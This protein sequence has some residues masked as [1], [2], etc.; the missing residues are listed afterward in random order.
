MA[1]TPGAH[2]CIQL[3]V[4]DT[5]CHHW[6]RI[7][8]PAS[9][10]NSVSVFSFVFVFSS[11]LLSKFKYFMRKIDC[12]T[13]ALIKTNCP[14]RK[15]NV[16]SISTKMLKS[17]LI[18]A[19]VLKNKNST[20]TH[21]YERGCLN[22]T[23][24]HTL[25]VK[26]GGKNQRLFFGCVLLMFV[27]V[28]VHAHAEIDPAELQLYPCPCP[29]ISFL[30]FFCMRM[31][32]E[33]K[34]ENPV[35][36]CSWWW[37]SCWWCCCTFL[38]L[39]FWKPKVT[40]RTVCT[41]VDFYLERFN[42]FFFTAEKNVGWHLY[43]GKIVCIYKYIHHSSLCVS[44]TWYFRSGLCGTLQAPKCNKWVGAAADKWS[45]SVRQFKEKKNI[46]WDVSK[47]SV[48]WKWN[49]QKNYNKITSL[50][51]HNIKPF[52]LNDL[53]QKKKLNKACYL[54]MLLIAFFKVGSPDYKSLTAYIWSLG[55]S[56]PMPALESVIA[57]HTMSWTKGCWC[58]DGATGT[59]LFVNRQLFAG[60]GQYGD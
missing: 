2:S 55:C 60:A 26:I 32:C 31:F 16:C 51:P 22:R 54:L 6:R 38:S 37:L 7:V 33:K 43:L 47:T 58:W 29:A 10:N 3:T 15:I 19:H 48:Y 44:L 41:D 56:L 52:Y 25:S 24:A 39:C 49:K 28:W 23:G 18:W 8:S 9:V 34:N 57:W 4:T 20:Q 13:A 50:K 45:F 53:K 35:C 11:G 17:A 30:V 1:I 14:H 27:C 5:W 46:S 12:A 40:L 21:A 59:V 36:C 42:A